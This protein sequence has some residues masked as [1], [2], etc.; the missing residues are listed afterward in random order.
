LTSLTAISCGQSSSTPSA[1]V[2]PT[3][4]T[5]PP[6]PTLKVGLLP[7]MDHADRQLSAATLGR[8]AAGLSGQLAGWGYRAGSEREFKGNSGDFQDVVSRTLLFDS[9][10]G[11]ESF[12]GFV[13]AHP[14]TWLGTL[15]SSAPVTLSG[16][17]TGFVLSPVPCGCHRETLLR[18]LLASHGAR[19]TWLMVNGP[20]ATTR[21]ALALAGRA[22]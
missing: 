16:K 17:R 2:L 6:Q 15:K 5:G 4:T 18:L 22:P 3:T 10:A 8:E 19:V 20:R 9:P 7:G 13:H 1:P 14:D 21:R 12:M 11:A